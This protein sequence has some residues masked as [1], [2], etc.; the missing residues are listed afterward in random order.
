M[1][2]EQL[3]CLILRYRQELQLER[4]RALLAEAELEFSRDAKEQAQDK[5]TQARQ[6]LQF[7]DCLPEIEQRLGDLSARTDALEHQMVG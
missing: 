3:T 1:F 5:L 2:S 7:S 6:A 4:A